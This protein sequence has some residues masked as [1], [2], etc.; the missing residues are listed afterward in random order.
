MRNYKRYEVQDKNAMQHWH[1]I[2]SPW[3]VIKNFIIIQIGRYCPSLTLKS[4][5]YRF[6]LG[7]KIGPQ[8]SIGL[9]VMVD[10]FFP[11]K[12]S[13]G[14][15]A[16]IGYNCTL[17]THEYLHRSYHLGPVVIGKCVLIGANTT[18]LPGVT[19]GDNSVVAAC[20]LVN[21][22]VPPNITVGGVPIQKITSG[23]VVSRDDC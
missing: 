11:E 6:G 23:P 4:W 15:D 14:E 9:M 19:I 16:T 22:D 10:I 12:I 8:A 7:M 1:Q 5:L 20:S 17:L 2:V 13:I 18:I 3:K 21:C